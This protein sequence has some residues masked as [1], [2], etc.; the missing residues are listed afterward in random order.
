[1]IVVRGYSLPSYVLLGFGGVGML[2]LPLIIYRFLR[3]PAPASNA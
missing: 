2:L 1:V 3:Q